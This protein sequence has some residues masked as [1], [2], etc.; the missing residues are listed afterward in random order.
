MK[1][2]TKTGLIM[3]ALIAFIIVGTATTIYV[4]TVN[5]GKAL[6]GTSKDTA[7]IGCKVYSIQKIAESQADFEKDWKVQFALEYNYEGNGRMIQT[8]EG[9]KTVFVKND[10]EEEIKIAVE[11]ICDQD[12]VNAQ[13]RYGTVDKVIVESKTNPILS[14]LYNP[15]AKIWNK[16]NQ[17]ELN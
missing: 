15:V 7:L 8:R 5:E 6:L 4:E 1:K 11:P 13:A 9:V 16:T 14:K 2:I 12:W 10:S 3:F 17:K